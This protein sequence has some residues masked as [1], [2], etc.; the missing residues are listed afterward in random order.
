MRKRFLVLLFVSALVAPLA[1]QV[2]AESYVYVPQTVSPEAA[3]HLR[4]MPDPRLGP[5]LPAP[6]D[7]DQ[8]LVLQQAFETQ[9]I[10]RQTQTVERLEPD[11]T[12]TDIGGIPV[13]DIKPR[14]W[15]NR[16]KLLVYTHGGAYT[17]NSAESTLGSSALM[18][19][20]TGLRV[21]S[22][23]YT[24]APHA[25]WQTVLGEVVAVFDGLKADGYAME[26]MAIYG[27]S[28]GG[29]LAAGA[30]LKMRDEGMGMPAAVVLWSP[31]SD[32]TET[33]D[34]YV[35]LRDA[36]P[37]YRYE[38]V[39]KPSADAYADPADQK[40][41]YVSPVYGDYTKGF[42]PTLIQGGTKEIFLSNFVRHYQAIDAAGRTVKLDLYEG[43]PH[44]FQAAIPR[45]PESELAL[46]KVDAFLSLYLRQ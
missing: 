38:T 4:M 28:A 37:A 1:A 31:W 43:M 41:P 25:Q 24:L 35:T 10:E 18:A 12:R 46:Q 11:V 17:L 30:V 3:A 36:E 6:D 40:N 29:G 23:D 22:I 27:D 26:D 20:A 15:R 21:I 45:S 42:P 9:N 8:W 39:L 5:A 16:A 2:P 14:N 13:L 32:I 44:V 34:T 7:V 33:G 19:D